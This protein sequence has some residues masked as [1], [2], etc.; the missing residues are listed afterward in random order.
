L[1]H[2]AHVVGIIINAGNFRGLG[3]SVVQATNQATATTKW[4]QQFTGRLR[5]TDSNSGV[6][7]LTSAW[8]SLSFAVG[9]FFAVGAIRKFRGGQDRQLARALAWARLFRS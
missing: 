7:F 8:R 4:S 9:D 1:F 2:P 5:G 6:G 3:D